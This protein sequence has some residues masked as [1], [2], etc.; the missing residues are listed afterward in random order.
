M[1]N[2]QNL[3]N[4]SKI[5]IPTGLASYAQLAEWYI[6]Q[7]DKDSKAHKYDKAIGVARAC[8]KLHSE[9]EV[10]CGFEYHHSRKEAPPDFLIYC[11]AN[12]FSSQQSSGI[13]P[14]WWPKV[15]KACI[16]SPETDLQ[17]SGLYLACENWIEFDQGS[18][19]LF[20]AGIWQMVAQHGLEKP[21]DWLKICSTIE[22]WNYP[23]GSLASS[24]SVAEFYL[25]FGFPTQ[26]G[27]MSGRGQYLKL[28]KQH[29]TPEQIGAHSDYISRLWPMLPHFDFRNYSQRIRD[30]GQLLRP[31]TSID[32]DIVNDRLLPGFGLEIHPAGYLGGPTPEYLH[33]FLTDGCHVDIA[34][35]DDFFCL[36]KSLPKG[37]EVS[38]LNAVGTG[39]DQS[40]YVAKFNHLKVV[41][42]PDSAPRL[43][44]YV[45][46]VSIHSKSEES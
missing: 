44:T 11:N 23:P 37:V 21:H 41:F 35:I 20:M 25:A 38:S 22:D 39:L 14:E 7:C 33:S 32:I 45:R 31:A 2:I 13:V 36:M 34:Q 42:S 8:D 17:H 16:T 24:T 19:G 30:A 6:D 27:I 43:K 3:I 10:T 15:Q 18:N 28:M 26:I 9:P 5:A 12:R 4:H 29:L 46:L 40:A 1:L